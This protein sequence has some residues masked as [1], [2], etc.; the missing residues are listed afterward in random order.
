V[1]DSLLRF[2]LCQI[3]PLNLLERDQSSLRAD[4]WTL[5]S[6]LIHSFIGRSISPDV[7]RF[8]REYERPDELLF[9]SELIPAYI[10][11]CQAMMGSV[12]PFI[13]ANRHFCSLETNDRSV[14]LRRAIENLSPISGGLITRLSPL[15]SSVAFWNALKV[16]Y[17]EEIYIRSRHFVEHFRSEAEL[18][19]LSLVLFAFS[20]CYA[21]SASLDSNAPSIGLVNI[22]AIVNIQDMYAELIWRY[23]LYKYTLEQAVIRFMNLI[24]TFLLALPVIVEARNHA[25]VHVEMIDSLVEQSEIALILDDVE[26]ESGGT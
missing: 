15:R 4:Q 5:L 14:L 6:N 20:T 9:M 23:L 26:H 3:A 8:I 16:I 12:C 13:E 22:K 24:E 11:I 1:F 2:S 17:G 25:H 10:D 18:H 19:K 7:E 21:P